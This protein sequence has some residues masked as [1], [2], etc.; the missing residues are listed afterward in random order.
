M[1]PYKAPRSLESLSC[2]LVLGLLY[3]LTIRCLLDYSHYQ[4]G[5]HAYYYHSHECDVVMH[6]Q[7]CKY[8]N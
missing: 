2:D 3:H 4:V 6:R 7:H 1:P 8:F 5:Q